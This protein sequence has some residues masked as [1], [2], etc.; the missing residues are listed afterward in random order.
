MALTQYF[1]VVLDFKNIKNT[2]MKKS[3]L[4]FLVIGILFSFSSCECGDTENQNTKEQQELVI[5]KEK[6]RISELLDQLATATESGNIQAIEGIWCPKDKSMLLGTENSEK[7]MGWAEIKKAISG[8]SSAFS[9]MLISIT[10]QNIWLDQD[11]GTAWF[12]EE[13][14]Y[15]F[16]YQDKAMSFEGIRF[17][18]VFVKSKEGDWKLI[19]GH[20]SVPSEVEVEE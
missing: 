13:L 10:D 4:Y 19:Q 11:G 5:E 9:E 1:F 18:G 2:D 15:N 12:F 6:A 16:I 7:L 3:F 8:Q 17:T 20:M 14:N